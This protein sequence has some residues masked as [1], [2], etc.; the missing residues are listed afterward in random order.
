LSKSVVSPRLLLGILAT[1]GASGCGGGSGTTDASTPTKAVFIRRADSICE[2]IDKSQESI[3]GKYFKRHPNVTETTA[4]KED[5]AAISVPPIRTGAE[6]LAALAAPS[7][8][9][10]EIRS[11]VLSIEKGVKQAEANPSTVVSEKPN[12]PFAEAKNLGRKYGFKACALP[13]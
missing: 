2:R 7:G 11:F 10:G 6:E 1:L 12:G 5:I 8:D 9:E 3:V 13:L 4:V